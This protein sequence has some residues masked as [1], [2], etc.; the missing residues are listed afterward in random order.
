MDKNERVE[1][2]KSRGF[3]YA[4]LYLEDPVVF[5]NLTVNDLTALW[6][7]YNWEREAYKEGI[8]VRGNHFSGKQ[9]EELVLKTAPSSLHSHFQKSNIT[10]Q[11]SAEEI[12]I[13]DDVYRDQGNI[14][15]DFYRAHFSQRFD[16]SALATLDAR[17]RHTAGRNFVNTH[18]FVSLMAGVYLLTPLPQ[19]V[20]ARLFLKDVIE[21]VAQ[22]KQTPALEKYVQ[23]VLRKSIMLHNSLETQYLVVRTIA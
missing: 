19:R 17:M 20:K 1:A 8:T 3:D 5:G 11:P 12:F 13:I 14:R 18:G 6:I 9:L 7:M 10:Q 16:E 15:D 2:L 4:A 21:A 22:Q 23:D